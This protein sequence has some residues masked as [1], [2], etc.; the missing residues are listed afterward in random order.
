MKLE[1]TEQGVVIPK[2]LLEGVKQVHVRKESDR[3]VVVPVPFEDPIL[4]IGKNPVKGGIT[5]ASVDLDKYIY[6]GK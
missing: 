2:S 5:D 4:R 3:I 6:T 1:V